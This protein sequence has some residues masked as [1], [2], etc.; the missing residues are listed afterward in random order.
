MKHYLKLYLNQKKLFIFT[1]IIFFILL[2]LF[3]A[4]KDSI[5]KEPIYYQDYPSAGLEFFYY[6]HSVGQNPYHFIC[7]LLLLPNIV[8][9]DYLTYIQKHTT[10]LIETRLT[11]KQFYRHTFLFN[12]LMTFIIV[13]FIECLVLIVIHIFYLPIV[14]QNT[15]YPEHYHAITQLISSHE[16]INL[17]LFIPMTAFGYSLISA[18]LMTLST[19][20]HN[21]YVYRCIGVVIGIGLVLFPAFLQIYIPI[22][23]LAYIIQI[24]NFVGLGI[25]GV[26]DN[27]LSMSHM[28]MYILCTFIYVCVILCLAYIQEKRRAIYG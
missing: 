1:V 5:Y 19:W 18:L 14:F 23:N 7:L 2:S 6:V 26:I 24:Q 28:M 8:S 12:I 4:F 3:F 10:Y 25:E 20:I 13:F 9:A 11:Q 27:P 22:D 17:L 15:I 21:V 16:I